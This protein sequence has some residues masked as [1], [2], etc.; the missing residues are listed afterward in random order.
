MATNP[1]VLTELPWNYGFGAEGDMWYQD[2][3]GLWQ[4]VGGTKT[5]GAVPTIRTDGTVA[6]SLGSGG[7][8]LIEDG[9]S[10]FIFDNTT[11]DILVEG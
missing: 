6:W 10:D 8:P 5:T 1:P 4:P 9:T 3:A 2:D 7:E 11:L